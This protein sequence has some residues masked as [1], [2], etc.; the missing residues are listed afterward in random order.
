VKFLA[1]EGAGNKSPTL[2]VP[3]PGIPSGYNIPVI[4]SRRVLEMDAARALREARR[5][6]GL[7][8]SEV[9]RRT[10]T[11]QPAIARIESGLVVPRIDTL[12]TLLRACGRTLTVVP[13]L[14]VEVDRQPIRVLLER[15][16]LARIAG[17]GL[18]AARILNLLAARRVRLVIVG[19]AAERIQGSPA[20]AHVL[21]LVVSGERTNRV[22]LEAAIARF[23][24]WRV[25]L[26]GRIRWR[27]R[28][29]P[30]SPPFEE[31]E[32]A[33]DDLPI[34]T[35]TIRIASLDDLIEMRRALTGRH[36]RERLEL[37]WAVREE[38]P[39]RSSPPRP[40]H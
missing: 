20:P 21:E 3:A 25:D 24:D 22:R 31:L 29:P 35:G 37:L 17:T 27:F 11:A 18:R 4:D 5:R 40:G 26:A 36:H 2:P 32:R 1:D 14:G 12:E 23:R 6:A 16:P 28:P 33:A 8:Q 34:G 38:R 13:R 15:P 7:S 10:G 39:R 9:A 19:A 30:G